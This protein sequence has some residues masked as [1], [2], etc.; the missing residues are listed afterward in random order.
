VLGGLGGCCDELLG[1]S[2]VLGSRG[3]KIGFGS[4]GADAEGDSGFF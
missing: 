3:V 2:P 4:F 1:E